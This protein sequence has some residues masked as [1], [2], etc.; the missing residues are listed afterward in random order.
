MS[1][2]PAT[3]AC[4]IFTRGRSRSIKTAPPSPRSD[5]EDSNMA[6]IADV[7]SELKS[8]R[9][10][11]GTKLDN[12]D[13]RLIVVAT[14][15]AALESKTDDLENRARRKNL[16]LFGIREGAEGQQTLLNFVNNMLTRWLELIPDRALTL[17]RVH[18][19]LPSG[20]PNQHRAVRFLKFQE[21]EFVD[22]ES[23][24]RDITHDGGKISFA[25]DLSAETVRI[26]RGFYTVT[27]LFVDINAFRGF[28]HNP[29]KL[30][31]LHNGKINLFTTPQEAEKF[32]K[33][34]KQ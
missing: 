7:L 12:I 20:K 18:R 25:Q 34:I 15:M 2:P 8:L 31:V 21:K 32:Y 13:T 22:H 10:D 30:R 23:R 9:A 1:N 16:R 6:N 17:E 3:K 29:C 14:S 26:R 11:F 27:K 4:D 28:Q 19:T 24:R 33:S 5:S